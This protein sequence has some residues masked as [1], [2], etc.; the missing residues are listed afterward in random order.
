V[1]SASRALESTRKVRAA[2]ASA[3]RV[4][5]RLDG[6]AA[7]KGVASGRCGFGGVQSLLSW[8]IGRQ[9]ANNDLLPVG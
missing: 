9:S 5:R 8:P 1:R 7:A 3:E 2:F 4:A 6:L